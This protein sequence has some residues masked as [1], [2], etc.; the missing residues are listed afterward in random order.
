MNLKKYSLFKIFHYLWIFL[1]FLLIIYIISKNIVVQRDLVYKLNFNK[2]IMRDITGWYPESRTITINNEL[3]ILEEPLYLKVYTP[4]RFN[5]LIIK[6]KIE[7]QEE[8]IKI[9]LKQKDQSYLYKDINNEDI[10]LSFSL[11]EALIV[12]NKLE[13]ILSLP[14]LKK[15]SNINL[16]DWVIILRR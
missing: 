1:A 12:G 5:N 9:G 16:K 3:H 7:F 4:L 14:D 10:N 6:G 15:I 13:L 11:E 2:S 8:A